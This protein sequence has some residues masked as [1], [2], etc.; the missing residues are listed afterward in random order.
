MKEKY[1][2][3][4]DYSLVNYK[5]TREKVTIICK[6]HGPFQILPPNHERG[7]G[8]CRMCRNEKRRKTKEEF[9]EEAI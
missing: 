2:D 8:G 9:I 4:Y 3:R 7:D 6:K 5:S 1:G